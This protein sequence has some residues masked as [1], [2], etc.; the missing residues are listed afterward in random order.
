MLISRKYK[1]RG[2]HAA[3]FDFSIAIL[4]SFLPLVD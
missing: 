3:C 1:T 4:A 2:L